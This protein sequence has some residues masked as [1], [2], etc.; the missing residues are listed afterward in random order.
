MDGN[1]LTYFPGGIEAPV[2]V[3]D[4]LTV[5]FHDSQPAPGRFQSHSPAHFWSA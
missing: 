3:A 1:R 4:E 5:D 2:V